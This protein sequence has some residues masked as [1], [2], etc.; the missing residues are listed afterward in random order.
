M[1][2]AELAIDLDE[3]DPMFLELDVPLL[4]ALSEVLV[5]WKNF[6]RL[7]GMI[8]EMDCFFFFLDLVKDLK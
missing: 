1:R 4:A 5:R 7:G 6:R 8:G 3:D 2:E